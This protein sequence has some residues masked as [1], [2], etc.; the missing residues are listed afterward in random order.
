MV[1]GGLAVATLLVLAGSAS[2]ALTMDLSQPEGRVEP[3]RTQATVT[4]SLTVDCQT[5]VVRNEQERIVT[6]AFDPADDVLLTGSNSK[7]FAADACPT[8]DGTASLTAD[9]VLT[10]TRDAPGLVPLVTSGVARLP[11]HATDSLLAPDLV[12]E[13]DVTLTADAYIL[14]EPR[15]A[16]K[17]IQLEGD[18]ATITI[19]LAN[20]GNVRLKVVAT[21]EPTVGT[22]EGGEIVL[23]TPNA[24]VL[25]GSPSGNLNVVFR[26]PPESFGQ[27][28]LTVR[29]TSSA[30]DDPSRMG[31]LLDANV[32]LVDGR[33]SD[34]SS[35]APAGPLVGLLLAGLATALRRRP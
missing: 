28:A 35:P 29:L 6:F 31:Q 33:P 26:A 20:R 17:R 12:A 32:L 8:P 3:E 34:R 22:F 14:V 5:L 18:N 1:P 15:V 24:D 25:Q 9:F 13:D 11:T 27:V 21:A 7:A 19:E 4:A 23:E 30:V 16:Q 10:V 2:A